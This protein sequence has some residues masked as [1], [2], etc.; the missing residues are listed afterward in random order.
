M[1]YSDELVW[2][3]KKSSLRIES[4]RTP[5]YTSQRDTGEAAKNEQK[6]RMRK[7]KTPQ[8]QKVRCP[9]S[10]EKKGFRAGVI[11]SSPI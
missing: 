5:M 2:I 7:K 1:R 3:E 8:N 4:W 9:G 10:Q 11:K 6:Q